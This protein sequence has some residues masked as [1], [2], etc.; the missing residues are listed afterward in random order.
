ML[1]DGTDPL[2]VGFEKGNFM[3][4][5]ILSLNLKKKLT[6]NLISSDKNNK[7]T[8]IDHLMAGNEVVV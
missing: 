7:N 2:V 5:T 3:G 6:E 8:H 1:L 4:A